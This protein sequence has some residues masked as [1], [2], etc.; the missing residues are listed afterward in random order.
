MFEYGSEEREVKTLKV[1]R[2]PSYL[3]EALWSLY[4]NQDK[5]R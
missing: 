2:R 1:R 5:T 4:I 3:C